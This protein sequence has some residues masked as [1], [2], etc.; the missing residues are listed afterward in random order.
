MTRRSS[1]AR[2][3]LA[4]GGIAL[5]AIL[6]IAIGSYEVGAHVRSSRQAAA[7]QAPAARS[8]LTVP[9]KAQVLRQTAVFRA[10]YRAGATDPVGT[11]PTIDGSD[12]V[13]TAVRVRAGRRITSG[14]VVLEVAGQPVVAMQG[15]LPMYRALHAGDAGPDVRELQGELASHHAYGGSTTGVFDSA[16]RSAVSSYLSERGYQLPT[17]GGTPHTRNVWIPKGTFLYLRRLPAKVASVNVRAGS[18]LAGAAWMRVEA[19]APSLSAALPDNVQAQVQS[20]VTVYDDTTA[21]SIK[22]HVL[23]VSTGKKRVASLAV[24]AGV[25]LTPGQEAL[26][27]VM[28][29]GSTK[30]A[31]L[32]VPIVA[33]HS[34]A[35]GGQYVV[36]LLGHQ[37]ESI[38]VRTGV[39]ANGWVEVTPSD[40]GA[41]FEP[42]TPV[43]V[44]Q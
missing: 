12:P 42:G 15:G 32:S 2:R 24:P 38:S 44:S 11:Y 22:T 43:V 23:A 13:V 30:R 4:R 37:Q 3:R 25:R 41:R 14:S 20:V 26:R 5:A 18:L 21:R 9:V 8:V 7:D 36:R 33:V 17:E 39:S 29:T 6:G 1:P 40:R 35:D 28:V 34:A 31:V 16:T 10:T 19:G 27:V